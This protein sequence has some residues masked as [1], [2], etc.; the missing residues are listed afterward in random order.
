ML[1]IATFGFFKTESLSKFMAAIREIKLGLNKLFLF[2]LKP[3]LK[4]EP[5]DRINI[6]V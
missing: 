1:R 6:S 2:I 5:F 4:L 3:G